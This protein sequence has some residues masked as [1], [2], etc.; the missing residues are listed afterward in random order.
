MTDTEKRIQTIL[1]NYTVEETMKMV[2]ELKNSNGVFDND[3]LVR[4]LIENH[5]Q[6]DSE[7]S[8]FHLYLLNVQQDLMFVMYGYVR[9]L[10]KNINY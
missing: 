2:E 5:Y 6:K 7:K 1:N 8:M 4:N 10:E 9:N 3:S